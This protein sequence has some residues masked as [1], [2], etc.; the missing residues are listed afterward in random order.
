MGAEAARIERRTLERASS[1]NDVLAPASWTDARVEAWLD[2]LG[3]DADLPAAVFRF[4]EDLVQR[5]DSAALFETAGAELGPEAV[6]R[7][8][9]NGHPPPQPCD[10]RHNPPL[11][12]PGGLRV[13]PRGG[14]CRR[15]RQQS[16][17]S[18][19]T[20]RDWPSRHR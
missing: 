13:R 20:P 6:A 2:W 4:A 7:H 12:Q 18:G 19:T 17:P 16:R 14:R 11:S 15:R 9:P 3:E 10:V 5:G 8:R 1:V